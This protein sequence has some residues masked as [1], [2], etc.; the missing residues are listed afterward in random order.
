MLH[1]LMGEGVSKMLMHDYGGGGGGW[2][3]SFLQNEKGFQNIICCF[4]KDDNL[5]FISGFSLI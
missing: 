3:M 1:N 4:I 2:Q 5:L